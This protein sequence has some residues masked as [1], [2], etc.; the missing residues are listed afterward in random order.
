MTRFSLLTSAIAVSLLLAAPTA[1]A[2]AERIDCEAV[3]DRIAAELASACPCDGF[4]SHGKY[5]R[6][7]TRT[8]RT[9]AECQT[10]TDGSQECG[11]VPRKCV[12]KIRRVASRSACGRGG[13]VTC[14]LPKQHD[15]RGDTTPGDGNKQGVCSGSK[16][17]CDTLSDCLLQ[18]CQLTTSTDH[19]K[20]A[21]GTLGQGKNCRTACR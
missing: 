17:R 12:G 16:E 7:I 19:C 4:P 5:V 15:C 21:G 10:A 2:Q 6:C 3:H 20:L 11:P 18:K 1:P 14:C 13:A 8:L 9:K